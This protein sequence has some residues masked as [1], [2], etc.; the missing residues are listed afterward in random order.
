MIPRRRRRTSPSSACRR[1]SRCRRLAHVLGEHPQGPRHNPEV[2]PDR[3][4]YRPYYDP[5]PKAPDKIVSKWG[6]FVPDVPFDPLHYGHA[7]EVADLDRAGATARAGGGSQ[8]RSTTRDIPTGRSRGNARPSS[9]AWGAA[10]RSSRWD[11]RPVVPADALRPGGPEA[12][13]EA[14]AGPAGMDRGLVPGIPPERRRR[15]RGEPVRPRRLELHRRRRVRVVAGRGEPGGPRA[16]G[17]RGDMV[18]LGG[19]D[20]VQNPFTYLAFSKT[21]A[22]SPRAAAGRSTPRPTA[23]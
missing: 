16:G 8:W 21:H 20:T 23:S 12:V 17:R 15:P 7:A 14:A 3:W 4:D 1:S 13:P 2:P 22:F 6:G 11:T 5:D 9:W 19:A 18:V 10:R